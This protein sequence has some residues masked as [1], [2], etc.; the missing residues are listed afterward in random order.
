KLRRP[1]MDPRLA[2]TQRTPQQ[3]RHPGQWLHRLPRE[4]L[5][6]PLLHRADGDGAQG[7]RC[8]GADGVRGEA[9]AGGVCT[10][11]ECDDGLSC[12]GV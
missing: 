1:P 12:C 3:I 5:L 9:G 10:A 6:P 4:L 7:P 2:Q 11:A 8:Y